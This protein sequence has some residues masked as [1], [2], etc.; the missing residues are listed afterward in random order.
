ME[1]LLIGIFRTVNKIFYSQVCTRQYVGGDPES[2]EKLMTLK[3]GMSLNYQHHWIVDNMP[4]TWC[5]QV[6]SN[7]QFCS[8]GFPMGCFARQHADGVN[9]IIRY[10]WC[11]VLILYLSIS[12]RQLSDQ[13]KLQQTG[14]LLSIQSRRFD[15]N[16][17]QRR[18]WG[19]GCWVWC[20][21]WTHY[22]G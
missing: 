21:W 22:L 16:I 11:R 3:K 8:T 14:R 17:P 20:K 6:E 2:I 18:N 4:V 10:L 15:D 19:M 1:P 13:S 12:V 9:C 5:Y 7:R